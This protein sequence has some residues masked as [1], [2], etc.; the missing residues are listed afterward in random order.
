MTNKPTKVFA[1]Y[2]SRPPA[3][4][5][6]IRTAFEWLNGPAYEVTLWENARVGGKVVIAELCRLIDGS[7]LFVADVTGI[8]PNVMFEL[9]YA[10]A[11]KKPVWLIFDDSRLTYQRDYEK[12]RLLTGV[13][14]CTYLNSQ[15]IVNG[16]YKDFAAGE[17]GRTIFGTEIEPILG[18]PDSN[19]VLYLRSRYQTDADRKISEAVARHAREGLPCTI[20]DPNETRVQPLAWY[21]QSIYSSVGILAHLC[22]EDREDGR[23][24]NARGAFVCGMASGFGKPNLILAEHD[25]TAPFDYKDQLINY[26]TAREAVGYAEVF[27][28]RTR[29]SYLS[30]MHP[31]RLERSGAIKLATE[32]RNLRVGEYVA[33]N[34]ADHLDDYFVETSAYREVLDGRHSIFLGRK[35]TGKTANLLRAASQLRADPRNLVVVIQPVGY[36]LAGLTKLLRSYQERDAKGYL[37]DSL[38]KFLIYSEIGQAA[39]ASIRARPSRAYS[40]SERDL[41]E[42]YSSAA[43]PLRGDFAIRLERVLESLEP[44]RQS[45]GIE[46]TRIAISEVLHAGLI[47][48]L[49]VQLGEALNERERV[50][51]LIDNLDR[52]WLRGGDLDHIGELIFGLLG[53]AERMRAD[54]AKEGHRRK[55]VKMTLGVFLRT[56]IFNYLTRSAREPDKLSFSRITWD[57]P[58]LLTRVLEER[59]I[60]ST[61]A[62]SAEEVW[63]R[64]FTP[65][66]TGIPIREYLVSRT[67]PRPRDIVY[68]TRAAV[69]TAINR[70]HARV[71]EADVFEAE[72]QYSQ[73]ALDTI[74]T[75]ATAEFPELAKLLYEFAGAKEILEKEELEKFMSKAGF[76]SDRFAA[77]AEFLLTYGFLGL[78]INE[79]VFDFASDENELR[80]NWVLSRKLQE[81]SGRPP[82][83]RIHKSFHS[84]L[85]IQRDASQ[86]SLFLKRPS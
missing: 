86:P 38:W 22:S 29:N 57:D 64:F 6:T 78:E 73:Y 5:E 69:S 59:L 11:S 82:R 70:G 66:V 50:A 76:E 45:S 77:A 25:Y 30:L 51:V 33:E 43:S 4:G 34:E 37:V 35:G 80:K 21:G 61:D 39:C 28:I 48:K 41:L 44:V 3:L 65:R 85:E 13:G 62:G 54:L 9:G 14:Y 63:E 58:E 15:D 46:A 74:E 27:L 72:K 12:F 24:H 71:E 68:L 49:R 42:S 26:S 75:E 55:A 53:A 1:A 67:L 18:N 16:F 8:N 10:I 60:A 20:D 17:L 2:P 32:L 79:D 83:F 36:D 47:S 31:I 56:D 7:D 52:A 23:I 19:G 40:A 81:R 84:Y